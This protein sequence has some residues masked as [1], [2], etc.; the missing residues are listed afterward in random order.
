MK[1]RTYRAMANLT[2]Q[3]LAERL[4]ISELSVIK[5]EGGT[6]IPSKEALLRIY[7]FTGGLVSPN[8][9]FDLDAIP[10]DGV[11][12]APNSPFVAAG[13]MSGT[14]MDGI[15]GTLLITDGEGF[16]K[17]LGNCELKYDSEFKILLKGCE[18]ACFESDGNIQMARIEFPKVIRR[19]ISQ[20]QAI[21]DV[22]STKLFDDL[23]FYF[24]G[25]KHRQITFDDVVQR[26]TEL[27]AAVIA[28][29]LQTTSYKARNV[30]I[31]GY[32]G[33]TLFHRPADGITIQVGNGQSLSDQSGIAV[34]HDFR[35]NDVRHGGQGAPF[36]PLYHRA[37]A[38]QI[39]L[40]PVVIANCGGIS[41]ITI[42]GS[43]D[44]DLYAY[45][46]GPGNTLIDRFVAL[47]VG[48][49]MDTDGLYGSQGRVHS[50]IMQL[51]KERAI[52]A[53]GG[54]PYLE[55]KPPKSLDANDMVLIPEVEALSLQDGCATLEAFTAECIVSSL[56]NLPSFSIPRLWVLA[57]GG[58]KN[59]TIHRELE[60]RL[61]QHLGADIRIQHADQ[62][63]WS[64]S[65][66]EAQIFAYL[67][68]RA[69]RKLPLSLPGTTGVPTPLTGGEI[70]VPKSDPSK[71][72]KRVRPFVQDSF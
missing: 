16:I 43:R 36:A 8:D 23:C 31:V 50:D 11:V 25:E 70:V 63:G 4:G 32:H 30:D 2:Q 6:T 54:Q 68:V 17:E 67:A 49:E 60:Q 51:L 15:D 5:Y 20:S 12:Q 13:L 3:A 35:T 58:W 71:T 46:C 59:K 62:V 41:N 44:E 24:F 57:G 56:E 55:R 34:V 38:S 21:T 1:L 69:L 64:G 65:A 10:K 42:I 33:Q 61:K 22:E 19:Y 28:D 47:K 18:R 29:L 45:D 72:T 48:R 26:S 7:Q 37:I 14:S 40:T 39:G 9:F 52:E 27:H 66:L 53:R